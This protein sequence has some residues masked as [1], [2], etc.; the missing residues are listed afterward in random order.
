MAYQKDFNMQLI[1][2]VLAGARGDSFGD[3]LAQGG[4]MPDKVALREAQVGQA[5]ANLQNTQLKNIELQQDITG[6]GQNITVPDRTYSIQEQNQDLSIAESFGM[7]DLAETGLADLGS[8][9]G[10]APTGGYESQIA[11]AAK[12]QINF[13][14]KATAADAWRGKPNNFLLQQII[15]LIPSSYFNGDAKAGAR[16][17]V[18]RNNFSSRISELDGQIGNAKAGSA[19]QANLVKTRANVK[20]MIDRLDVVQQGFKGITPQDGS[21]N[22]DS[23][24]GVRGI[25]PGVELEV[26]EAGLDAMQLAYNEF[27]EE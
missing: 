25:N 27:L 21:L 1:G 9:V 18:I 8:A 10:L 14:I 22:I 20:H 7:Y 24:Y 6:A 15:E 5:Q 2:A 4:K 3:A 11:E 26:D 16:Y 23:F 17:G 12:K 13:D 19:A